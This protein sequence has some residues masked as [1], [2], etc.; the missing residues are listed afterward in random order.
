M[1]YK[2]EVKFLLTIF[3]NS[4]T[5]IKIYYDLTYNLHNCYA[6]VTTIFLEVSFY[7]FPPSSSQ[8]CI[9]ILEYNTFNRANNFFEMLL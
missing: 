1:K 4:H 5:N 8:L 2:V 6:V 7:R 3:K 9:M